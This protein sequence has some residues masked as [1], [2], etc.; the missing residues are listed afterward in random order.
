M[1]AVIGRG[2]DRAE[3]KMILVLVP[4]LLVLC[5]QTDHT[6]FAS[7]T[8][9]QRPP[10]AAYGAPVDVAKYLPPRPTYEAGGSYRV[11]YLHVNFMP[12]TP[13][14]T[15][16]KKPEGG[17]FKKILRKKTQKFQNAHSLASGFLSTF[18]L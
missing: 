9:T 17:F 10:S 11:E 3:V 18:H 7:D 15:T 2:R 8:T 5:A 16:T 1:G 6:N 13:P 14:Q 12:A 4:L